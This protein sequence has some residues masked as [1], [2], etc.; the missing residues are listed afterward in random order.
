MTYEHVADDRMRAILTTADPAPEEVQY[1]LEHSDAC[2]ML[3][4]ENEDVPHYVYEA[5]LDA[6]DAAWQSRKPSD[7]ITHIRKLWSI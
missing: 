6:L 5:R 3:D 7:A 4:A 1:A 2:L